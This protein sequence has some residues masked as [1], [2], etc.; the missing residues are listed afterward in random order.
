MNSVRCCTRQKE[1]R[2][3]YHETVRVQGKDDDVKANVRKGLDITRVSNYRTG[4]DHNLQALAIEAISRNS[5]LGPK[6]SPGQTC[7]L[8]PPCKRARWGSAPPTKPGNDPLPNRTHRR[9]V[10]SNYGE[11]IC[12]ASSRAALLGALEGCI[13]GHDPYFAIRINRVKALGAR[14]I[15][16]TRAFIAIGVLMGEGHSFMDDLESFFWVRAREKLGTVCKRQYFHDTVLAHFTPYYRPLIPW[17]VKLRDIVFPDNGN[18]EREDDTLY[19]RMRNILRYGR[20]DS[21]VI[22]E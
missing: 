3:Y 11:P 21:V 5:S 4:C 15:T 6:R 18:W 17:A 13:R 20:N 19:L 2:H 8:L 16:G 1:T 12:K 9:I 7:A 10:L 22:A 14:E